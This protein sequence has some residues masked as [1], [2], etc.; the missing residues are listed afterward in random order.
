MAISGSASLIKFFITLHP[1]ASAQSSVEGEPNAP[2]QPQHRFQSRSHRVPQPVQTQ[3]LKAY[4]LQ[5]PRQCQEDDR[6]DVMVSL[7]VAQFG[8]FA[9]EGDDE[10][11]KVRLELGALRVSWGVRVENKTAVSVEFDLVLVAVRWP[12][13]VVWERGRGCGVDIEETWPTNCESYISL[14]GG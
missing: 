3:L 5:L 4:K 1:T 10:G 11:M 13:M 2:K 12:T 14:G 8:P 6:N 9:E 7:E